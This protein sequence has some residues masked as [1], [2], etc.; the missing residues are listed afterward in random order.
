MARQS[1]M[2]NSA[3]QKTKGGERV[4]KHIIKPK[5]F[6]KDK[7]RTQ[8]NDY[9]FVETITTRSFDFVCSLEI[10]KGWDAGVGAE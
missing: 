9:I 8:Q 10:Q 7:W 1:A 3:K 2:H 5:T 4:K 6:Q